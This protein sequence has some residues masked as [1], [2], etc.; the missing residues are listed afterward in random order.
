MYLKC[1]FIYYKIVML[2]NSVFIIRF[3]MLV[4]IKCLDVNMS[5]NYSK[6]EINLCY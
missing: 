6:Y 4:V 5:C 2:V 1:C 3:M